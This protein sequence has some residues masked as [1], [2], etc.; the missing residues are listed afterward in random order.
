[1]NA[2]YSQRLVELG[3]HHQSSYNTMQLNNGN[4]GKDQKP[5]FF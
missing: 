4:I 2:M 5:V 1:M 3:Q